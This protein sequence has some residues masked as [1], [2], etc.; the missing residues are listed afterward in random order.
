MCILARRGGTLTLGSAR[1]KQFG[2]YD[3]GGGEEDFS[4]LV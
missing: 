2:A 1:R 4:E 3:L